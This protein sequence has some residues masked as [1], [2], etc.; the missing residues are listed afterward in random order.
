[1]QHPGMASLASRRPLLLRATTHISIMKA[2]NTHSCHSCD[3]SICAMRG[4]L[5]HKL[6]VPAKCMRLSMVQC[7]VLRHTRQEE[8]T[9][10]FVQQPSDR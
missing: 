8:V 4:R 7:I 1:M 9:S 6:M 3:L 5:L 10:R 2:N